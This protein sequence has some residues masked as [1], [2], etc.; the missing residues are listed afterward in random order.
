MSFLIP[1]TPDGE[2]RLQDVLL[3]RGSLRMMFC[4][5][6]SGPAHSQAY[7]APTLVFFFKAAQ[8][9]VAHLEIERAT[10][11]LLAPRPNQLS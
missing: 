1:V 10:L 6:C 2:L 3:T 7:Q 4:S 5:A 9:T 11:A 8:L